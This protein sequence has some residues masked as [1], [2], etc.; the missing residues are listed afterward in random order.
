MAFDP[1][2]NMYE[3]LQYSLSQEQFDFLNAVLECDTDKIKH[4][5]N[6]DR[7]NVNLGMPEKDFSILRWA[8]ET[9]SCGRTAK[10][11]TIKLLIENGAYLNS[12][13]GA[14]SSSRGSMGWNEDYENMTPIDAAR[15]EISNKELR[16]KV[17]NL[18]KN[19]VKENKMKIL[20]EKRT[21]A[22]T[23]LI[24]GAIQPDMSGYKHGRLAHKAMLQAKHPGLS[25]YDAI[26]VEIANLKGQPH[27]EPEKISYLQGL[28]ERFDKTGA[29]KKGPTAFDPFADSE[30]AE[31]PKTSADKESST[32][33]TEDLKQQLK[34]L[35]GLLQETHSKLTALQMER[36]KNPEINN[37][38]K[39]A[40][41]EAQRAT[42]ID[43]I[44][45]IKEKLHSV[46]MDFGFG[47]AASGAAASGAAASGAGVGGRK[48]RRTRKHRG[49]KRKQTKRRKPRKSTRKP[50]R[51]VKKR[52][53]TKRRKTRK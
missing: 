11:K 3:D 19:K 48:K 24:E 42:L 47:A 51:R 9:D 20:N 44:N 36:T 31:E 8:I 16:N 39:I 49:K 21:H 30:G 35:E 43:Q 26:N 45:E 6:I 1:L 40:L 22:A 38:S 5:I 15:E 2:A 28:V 13:F 50:K 12:K 10:L 27:H 25:Y 23:K 34:T 29:W 4:S 17:I 33:N 14:F 46:P 52:K 32:I 37:T 53:Q 41:K 7:V 18:I